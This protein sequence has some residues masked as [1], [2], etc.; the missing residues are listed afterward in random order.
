MRVNGLA[1]PY[2]A[3]LSV[4]QSTA[5]HS[6]SFGDDF[7]SVFDHRWLAYARVSQ[8]FSESV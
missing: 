7:S 2:E 5:R 6:L 3:K 8:P 1:W 4:A